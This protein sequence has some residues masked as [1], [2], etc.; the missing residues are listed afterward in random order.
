MYPQYSCRLCKDFLKE[1][2]LTYAIDK[3][4]GNPVLFCNPCRK[5]GE[6][7]SRKEITEEEFRKLINNRHEESVKKDYLFALEAL[8]QSWEVKMVPTSGS[9]TAESIKCCQLLNWFNDLEEEQKAK[10]Y[11]SLIFILD[12]L[13]SKGKLCSNCL[14]FKNNLQQKLAN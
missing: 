7:F 6:R 9:K 13:S 4:N 14:E 8:K 10:Q 11:S 5:D 3:R 12:N 2:N 1:G